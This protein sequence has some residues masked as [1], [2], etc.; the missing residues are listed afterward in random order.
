[1]LA[2]T[3]GNIEVVKELLKNRSI[4]VN[5]TDNESGVNAFWLAAY[6]GRGKC[7]SLLAE[8]QSN[9]LVKHSLSK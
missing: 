7:L 9:I 4:D 3:I 1:M 5:V 2:A 8:K 6:F